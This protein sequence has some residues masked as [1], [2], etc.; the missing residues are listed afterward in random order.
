MEVES[1]VAEINAILKAEQWPG[2]IEIDASSDRFMVVRQGKQQIV[3]VD[4][5]CGAS[6]IR[7]SIEGGKQWGLVPSFGPD[8]V[9]RFRISDTE[10][11]LES[12]QF[13]RRALEALF[14]DR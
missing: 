5:V 8:G 4:F 10:E 14:F 12:W 13:R 9:C 6:S 2:N 7:V 11:E 3:R 1:D